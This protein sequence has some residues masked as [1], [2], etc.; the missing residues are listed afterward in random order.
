MQNFVV[1]KKEEM[2]M[3]STWDHHIAYKVVSK[4]D[5]YTTNYTIQGFTEVSG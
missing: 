2:K 1:S 4:R 3:N 5:K